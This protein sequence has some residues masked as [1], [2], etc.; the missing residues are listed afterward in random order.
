MS[1][2]GNKL[3][4]FNLPIFQLTVSQLLEFNKIGHGWNAQARGLSS[5]LSLHMQSDCQGHVNLTSLKCLL[6]SSEQE[7][8]ALGNLYSTC[9]LGHWYDDSIYFQL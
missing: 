8:V 9:W 6:C 2:C 5:A 4:D 1:S 3:A 7:P